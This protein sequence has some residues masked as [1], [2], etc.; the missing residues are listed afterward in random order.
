MHGLPFSSLV[1]SGKR[2]ERKNVLPGQL[3]GGWVEADC[4]SAQDLGDAAGCVAVWSDAGEDQCGQ[5]AAADG[6]DDDAGDD[7]S[8]DYEGDDVAG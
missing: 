6:G 5:L 3:S 2:K 1:Q 8:D 7:Q 4:W